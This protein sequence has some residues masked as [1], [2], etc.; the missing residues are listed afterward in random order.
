MN[1]YLDT[2]LLSLYQER[3]E[4]A[5]EILYQK[6]EKIINMIIYKYKERIK[7]LR[8]NLEDIKNEC[9]L[10]FYTALNS[11][12]A[13]KNTTLS[14][15]VYLI[16]N[17][18]IKSILRYEYSKISKDTWFFESIENIES[19]TQLIVENENTLDL[20]NDLGTYLNPEEQDLVKYLYNGY[21]YKEIAQILN[22]KY[23]QVY[24]LIINLRNKLQKFQTI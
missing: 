8:I 12:D 16:I 11:F 23:H 4:V 19:T 21:N 13:K 9:M 14:T 24:W 17:R 2:E 15:Y 7:D 18:R 1:S 10:S 5:E 20:L 22:K 6:Y 3:N